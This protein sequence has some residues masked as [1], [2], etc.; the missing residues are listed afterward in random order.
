MLLQDNTT[1]PQLQVNNQATRM[2]LLVS[3]VYHKDL[4]AKRIR[5][6]PLNRTNISNLVYIFKQDALCHCNRLSG[7]TAYTHADFT[8][9]NKTTVQIP[10][11][12]LKLAKAA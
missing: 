7:V 5:A 11:C 2:L 9:R 1:S 3:R 10:P 4:N 8:P 6:H 12:S